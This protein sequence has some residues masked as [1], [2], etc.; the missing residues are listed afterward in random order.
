MTAKAA[1]ESLIEHL[2]WPRWLTSVGVGTP[3]GKE[4]IFVYC[5]TGVRAH[6][7]AF[8]KDGWEGYPVAVRCVG[9][10]LAW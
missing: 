3:Q 9:R 5:K 10:I 8:L 2:G 6:E 7:L 1:A 4:T